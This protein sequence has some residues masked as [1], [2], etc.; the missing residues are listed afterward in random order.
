[1]TYSRVWPGS[2]KYVSPALGDPGEDV[3]EFLLGDEEGVVGRLDLVG[4]IHVV[5]ADA[6]GRLHAHERA[7]RGR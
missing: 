4:V 3:V 7:K 5:Q 6:V 1:M 2:A